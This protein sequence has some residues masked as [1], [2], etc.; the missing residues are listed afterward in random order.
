MIH[1]YYESR[2]LARERWRKSEHGK[3]YTQ[4]YMREYRR[5]PE[6]KARYHEYYIKNKM[7]WGRITEFK[8]E[9][10]TT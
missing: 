10:Q 1:K 7:I 6:V 3:L 4:N 9:N 8:N 2:K 5:R